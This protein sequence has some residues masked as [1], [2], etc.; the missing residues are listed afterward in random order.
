M[1]TPNPYFTQRL[2]VSDEFATRSRMEV[3]RKLCE[4]K[5]VLHVG[6]VDWPITDVRNSLHIQ[7]DPVCAVLDGYDTHAEVFDTI[8]PHV[9]GRLF[10]NWADVTDA[11][12]VVLVP[13]VLE[14][15]S[16]VQV[17]LGQLS[18]LQASTFV[19]T[20]PDAFRCRS[21]FNYDAETGIFTERV[22]PDHNCW[23]SPYT[24]KNVLA[25]YTDWKLRGLWFFNRISLLA[26]A[27]RA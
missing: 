12:D 19:L 13:E 7:L 1:T 9:R 16:N 26:I 10:C 6:C 25:K 24:L 22:H 2:A 4:G 18:A 14:H 11:Y 27:D 20:V 5:R 17:F 8:R 23:Y 3:F 21:H 15:V